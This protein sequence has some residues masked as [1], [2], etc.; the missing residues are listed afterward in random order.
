MSDHDPMCPV[1]PIGSRCQCHLIRTIRADER[2]QESLRGPSVAWYEAH[3][4]AVRT[5]L[6]AKVE[7]LP[8]PRMSNDAFVMDERWDLWRAKVLALFDG[9]Q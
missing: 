3:D 4:R 8:R 5:D 1:G 6:H 2:K 9:S 7:A